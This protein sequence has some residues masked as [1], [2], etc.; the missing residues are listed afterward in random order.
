M[1]YYAKLRA[2]TVVEI[3]VVADENAPDEQ[4]GADHLATLTGWAADMES[5]PTTRRQY[6]MDYRHLRPDRRHVSTSTADTR[7]N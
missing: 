3:V 1:K 6:R 5:D 2:D 4:T 7:T